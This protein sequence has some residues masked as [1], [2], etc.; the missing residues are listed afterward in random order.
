MCIIPVNR[1]DI[2]VYALYYALE[3]QDG[4]SII[5]YA[6]HSMLY[7]ERSYGI[8]RASSLRKGQKN[9]MEMDRIIGIV[10]FKSETYREVAEDTTATTKAGIIVAIVAIITGISSGVM[11]AFRLD[12]ETFIMIIMAIF[13]P[14]VQI[15][16]SLLGWLLGGWLNA[17]VATK[18]FNGD[19]DT[20]EMLRVFGYSRIFQLLA[21]I[22]IVGIV[23]AILSVIGNVIGIREAAEFSTG[24]AVGT[25]I[26][27]GLIVFLVVGAIVGSITAV[28]MVVLGIGGALNTSY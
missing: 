25:A 16:A 2:P 27:S 8:L 18:L 7:C 3:M 22:P 28:L 17:T 6:D 14:I 26:I 1:Y 19:T 5:V 15:V 23:G 21:A 24:K 20:G 13:I 10:T 9:I 4:K 11:T 12:T